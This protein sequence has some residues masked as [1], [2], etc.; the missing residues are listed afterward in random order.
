MA[1]PD[2][3]AGLLCP[4]MVTRDALVRV[5]RYGAGRSLRRGSRPQL[6]GR[7]QAIVLAADCRRSSNDRPFRTSVRQALHVGE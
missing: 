7:R 3:R 6:P 2:S 1:E 4:D 5:W